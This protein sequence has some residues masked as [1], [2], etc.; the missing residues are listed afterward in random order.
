M[1]TNPNRDRLSIYDIAKELGVDTKT[2]QFGIPDE[3]IIFRRIME[4]LKKVP[5]IQYP[6]SLA[7]TDVILWR[8][9]ED[10]I[11]GVELLIGRKPYR[12]VWQF[13]GG[14]RDPKETSEAGALRELKEE[15]G[16]SVAIEA[17]YKNQLYLGSYFIDDSRYLVSCHKVTTSLFA[18]Q[19]PPNIED[20]THGDDIGEVKWVNY[21]ELAKDYQTIILPNHWVLFEAYRDNKSK[22]HGA[23]FR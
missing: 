4:Q 21:R 8:Y 16:G 11:Q 19:L 18:V 20:V 7:T 17:P 15:T 12:D 22:I 10:G 5:Y 14:F 1:D 2:F 9:K 6:V 3:Q 13:L 23:F